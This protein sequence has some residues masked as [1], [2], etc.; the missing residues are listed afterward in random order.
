MEILLDTRE[1]NL[2]KIQSKSIQ[3]SVEAKKMRGLFLPIA[4]SSISI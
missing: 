2:S 4:S 3:I 1:I